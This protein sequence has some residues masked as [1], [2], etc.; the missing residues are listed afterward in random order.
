M[1]AQLPLS[2]VYFVVHRLVGY[3]LV[4]HQFCING[5]LDVGKDY[6]ASLAGQS[7]AGA[8]GALIPVR[9]D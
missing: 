3:V 2:T 5:F 4:C 8:R 1:W 6:C 9:C 7:Q